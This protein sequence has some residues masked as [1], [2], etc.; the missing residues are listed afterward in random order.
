MP[1]TT[2]LQCPEFRFAWVNTI[3]KRA[4]CP[5]CNE[6]PVAICNHI[7]GKVYYRTQCDA[8]IRKGKKLRPKPPAWVRAGYKKKDRCERCGFKAHYPVKQLRVFYVDGNLKNN[9]WA[10]LKTVCLNCQVEVMES[11]LPW[12]PS[13]LVPDF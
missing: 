11:Q 5:T 7:K 8:C 9:D 10:N 4:I 6:R 3:M 2:W 12:Q 13:D 1:K